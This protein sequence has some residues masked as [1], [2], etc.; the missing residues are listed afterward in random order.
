MARDGAVVTRRTADVLVIEINRPEVRNAINLAVAEG[1]HDAA[2]LLD[3]DDTLRVGVL[4]G[5]G[6]TFSAGMDLRAF[7]AG[8]MPVVSGGGFAG[9]TA[10]PPRKPLVAAVEGWA[11]A[12]GLELMLA[13]DLAVAAQD[14]RFGIPE[15]R[16]GLVADSGALVHLPRR[17]PYALAARMAL[18]GEPIGAEQALS[19][20][21][22]VEVVPSGTALEAAV[23]LAEQ[24]AANAPLA[25]RTTKRVLEASHA[26]PSRG[27]EHAQTQLTAE[28]QNSNDAREGARAFVEKRP[29]IWSGS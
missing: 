26:W 25:V 3:S 4:T 28:I 24:I 16:V 17:I 1:L 15:V 18:T 20:G 12:G 21:L 27:W 8:Q 22:I 14:A 13:C 6:G 9:I 2:E 11:L 19:V 10:D 29:P 23:R 7:G 5:A